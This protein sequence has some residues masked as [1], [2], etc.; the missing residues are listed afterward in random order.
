MENHQRLPISTISPGNPGN[1][2]GPTDSP[3]TPDNRTPVTA[4]LAPASTGSPP[5]GAEPTGAAGSPAPPFLIE[6]LRLSAAPQGHGPAAAEGRF[7]PGARLIVAAPALRDSGLLSALADEGARCLIAMFSCLTP[8]GRLRP[9]VAELSKVTGLPETTVRRRM[10]RLAG[11]LWRGEPLV[12]EVACADSGDTTD[13]SA[14][15]RPGLDYYVPSSRLVCESEAPRE[16]APE[17]G[18]TLPPR[19]A[20]RAAVLAHSRHHYAR[21]RAEVERDILRQLGHTPEVWEQTPDGDARR[22]LGALGVPRDDADRL[23]REHPLEDVVAQLDW[24]PYRRAKNPARLIVAAI[25]NGY[26]PPVQVRLARAM[27]ETRARAADST[28]I[29][30]IMNSA[31]DASVPDRDPQADGERSSA[32]LAGAS[33]GEMSLIIPARADSTEQDGTGNT[34]DAADGGA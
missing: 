19:F 31:G 17:S 18:G 8:N 26:E 32:L 4:R 29:P 14:W 10:R 16:H 15:G 11:T 6:H 20:G 5:P 23:V 7:V 24:L 30:G 21:P 25:E 13:G 34:P 9:T 27:E 12:Q 22:R 28:E 1:P 2:G 3:R 33:A